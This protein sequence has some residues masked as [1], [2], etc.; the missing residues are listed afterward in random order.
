MV[1]ASFTVTA[2]P[3]TNAVSF[4]GSGDYY[5]ATGITTSATD[6]NSLTIVCTFYWA[7][8]D[9]LQHI[10]NLRLG[11]GNSDVGFYM[12]INGG[13]TQVTT[14]GGGSEY[15]TMYEN[16]ENS[17]TTDAYN[18][19]VF[20]MQ[21]NSSTNSRIFINGSSKAFTMSNLTNTNFNWGNT[22]TTIT[23]GQKQSAITGTGVDLNGRISQLYIH[24][25]SGAPAIS[26]VWNSSLG[27]PRNLGTNGA[28]VDTNQPLIYH[29]GNT[30]T[31]A[32]NNGTGFASYTLTANGNI[33]DAV[34]P[35]YER[36]T[37]QAYD[38]AQVDTAQSKFGGAS[39]LFDGTADYLQM[40]NSTDF[41]FTGDW[42]IEF[43][44]RQA[45]NVAAG[46]YPTFIAT[47]AVSDNKGWQVSSEPTNNKVSF[48]ASG[49]G[50]G[51]MSVLATSATITAGSFNHIAVVRASS[52]ITIYV[53]GTA[54]GS[55][56][57]TTGNTVASTYPLYIGGGIGGLSSGNFS[58]SGNAIHLNAHLDEIRISNTARYTTTFSAP[59][60]AFVNDANTLLLMHC[61]GTDASTTFTDDQS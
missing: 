22:A 34:G 53:N 40:A 44:W 13:R 14:V 61:D 18:Q 3:I 15:K 50:S 48:I 38:N 30:A 12:W 17:L 52:V 35:V 5:S 54:S 21:A 42:T 55:T 8:G 23:I 56:Y 29:Y 37:I 11:T 47:G 33:S 45:A 1:G 16:T 49:T 20:Y 31:F 51:G 7:G 39:A 43:Q 46:V 4:D 25:Q 26:S 2:V 36:N 59:T 28:R 41:N 32:A 9:N 19:V 58:S 60:V 6:A 57:T 27:R 10:V 24:N